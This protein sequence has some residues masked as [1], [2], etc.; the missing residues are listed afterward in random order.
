M[1]KLFLFSVLFIACAGYGQKL[2]KLTVEK[3]MRD[4]KWIGTSPTRPYWST[5]SRYLFF[6]WNPEKAIS[7]SVYYIT[8]TDLKPRKTTYAFR[9]AT[10]TKG[11]SI[12]N[13][14]RTTFVYTQD[15]DLYYVDTKTNKALQVTETVDME[16]NPAFIEG[17]KRIAYSRNQN[18]Y[19]WDIATGATEQLSNFQKGNPAKETVLSAQEKWLQ[20]NSL[21]TSEVLRERKEKREKAEAANKTQKGKELRTIYLGEKN[22]FNINISPDGRY[23]TYLLA[24]PV[25]GNKNTI[26]PSFV[27]ESGFTTDINSRT[28]VGTTPTS[29]EL[30]VYDRIQNTV[31]QV[32]TDKIAGIKDLPD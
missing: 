27:T 20:Q 28:K 26:V 25:T 23:V 15:G 32:K 19:A 9:Q 3:I 30:Y 4:P 6:S 1:K 13:N 22:I 16:Y 31:L 5:D 14:S 10:P 24:K 8:T 17:D 11:N 29:N 7:D 2:E 18:L 21:A 12:Y